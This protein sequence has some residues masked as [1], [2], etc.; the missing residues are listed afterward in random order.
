MSEELP[1]PPSQFMQP[2]EGNPTATSREGV[3]QSVETPDMPLP[4]EGA[5]VDAD[6]SG[7]DVGD[8][9]RYLPADLEISPHDEPIVRS[10]SRY[11][12][13]HDVTVTQIHRAIEWERGYQGSAAGML[14][15][16]VAHME[17]HGVS[18]EQADVAL[19]WF[20]GYAGSEA[21]KD[22]AALAKVDAAI[23]QIQELMC[24][25]AYDEKMQ[26]DYRLLLDAGSDSNLQ[27]RE[28]W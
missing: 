23:A 18:R 24:T 20:N 15:S 2:A 10:F 8:V 27:D 5:R 21:Q 17:P 4:A 19:E 1:L 16:F 26:S 25:P 3:S 12:S 28:E 22:D 6:P 14:E 9:F 11:M 13:E 7:F